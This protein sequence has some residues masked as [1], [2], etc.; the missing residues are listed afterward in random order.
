[1]IGRRLMGARSAGGD[2]LG[3]GIS[4]NKILA[5]ALRN[6]AGTGAWGVRLIVDGVAQSLR[7]LVLSQ[8]IQ[9]TVLIWH[10]YPSAS[11]AFSFDDI[12]KLY[13]GENTATQIFAEWTAMFCLNQGHTYG[14]IELYSYTSLTNNDR[15][16]EAY[17][18]D[19]DFYSTLSGCA[20]T[21]DGLNQS[22]SAY[23]MGNI[24]NNSVLQFG[25]NPKPTA[26]VYT[27]TV[28]NS[29]VRTN[30]EEGEYGSTR[31]H[32]GRGDI[33]GLYWLDEDIGDF[34]FD[35]SICHIYSTAYPVYRLNVSSGIKEYY[36]SSPLKL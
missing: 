22:P 11:F 6:N 3:S 14:G 26:P 28:G 19:G 33:F 24:I 31:I 13:K 25:V 17:L 12:V 36:F 8:K 34:L 2:V 7:S 30:H 4:A 1:M 29:L 18:F 32:A 20:E 9:P 35:T 21:S 16:L 5:L 23:T 15:G 10:C 27:D